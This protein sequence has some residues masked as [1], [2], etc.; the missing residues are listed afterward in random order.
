MKISI[1][2]LTPGM[3]VGDVFNDRDVLLY[4]AEA[5]IT[6][7]SQ[8]AKLKNHGVRFVYVYPEK[9]QNFHTAAVPAEELSQ[10]EIARDY[11]SQLEKARRAYLGAVSVVKQV[12]ESI[13]KDNRFDPR[14]IQYADNF[15]QEVIADPDVFL[16]VSRMKNSDEKLYVHSVNVAILTASAT[17]VLDYASEDIKVCVIGAMLHDLGLVKLPPQLREK[18]RSL[19]SP[20]SALI[21]KHPTLGLEMLS[22]IGSF[23]DPA[24][25]IV[26]QHHERLNGSGYPSR[27][28]GDQ[29]SEASFICAIADV[30]D[31]FVTS[32]PS[33]NPCSPQEALA[34][35]FQ[36]AGEEYPRGLVEA[37]TRFLGIYPVGSFVKLES[38]EMGLVV[39][40]NRHSL[41]TPTLIVC[42]DKQGKK[43]KQPFFRNLSAARSE[44]T[45]MPWRVEMSL[46]PLSYGIEMDMIL[47]WLSGKPCSSTVTA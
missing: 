26:L 22:S 31:T 33:R 35:I 24:K 46:N 34:L 3:Y 8:I 42:T 11:L 37:F 6:E 45:P 2:E 13:L 20:E 41:L 21:K 5:M 36:G 4:S 1:D 28:K 30:Y 44:F 47:D 32:A 19:T 43:L 10:A 12:T 40:N 9:G 27:L 7:Q 15:V 17:Q 23:P 38:G 16:A 39:K 18:E 14:I 29:I 25:T